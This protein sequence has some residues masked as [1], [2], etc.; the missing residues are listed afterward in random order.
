[1]KS[2]LPLEGVRRVLVVSWGFW[3]D[4]VILTPLLDALREAFPG[5][6]TH[7][8]I[9]PSPDR[10]RRAHAEFLFREDPRVTAVL[11][12]GSAA[13]AALMRGRRFDLALDLVDTRITR[14]FVK[15][16]GARCVVR[17]KFCTKIPRSFAR[18]TWGPDGQEDLGRIPLSGPFA[19]TYA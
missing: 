6:R 15:A 10:R 17:A 5:A 11:K 12:I 8:L 19:A 1:M 14:L 9:G 16:S 4:C 7:L 13:M 18:V 3:G 2:P